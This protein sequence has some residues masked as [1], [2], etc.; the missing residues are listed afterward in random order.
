MSRRLLVG[1]LLCLAAAAS[2][3]ALLGRVPLTPSG[4]DY[5]AYYDTVLDITWLAHANAGAGSI[6]DDGSSTTD[7]RMSWA[8][9]QAWIAALNAASHLGSSHWRL[10]GVDPINGS[11]FDYSVSF[12]GSTDRGYNQSE[13]GTA[14][15]GAT[16]SEMAHLFFNT[17]D[18]KGLCDPLLSTVS[19]C[20]SH[21]PGWG[22]SNTGPFSNLQPGYY[23][24]GTTYGLDANYAWAFHFNGGSQYGGTKGSGYYAWAVSPGDIEVVPV[25]AAAWMLGSALGALGWVRR[26]QSQA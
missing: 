7:G 3:A 9:A 18:N 4:T 25:P 17:L 24:S 19:S 13:Q 6:H 5:Q 23:W 8:S 10:P 15:A 20:S 1:L 21:P 12:N 16:G 14:Y 11:S 2:N 26:R 22:L